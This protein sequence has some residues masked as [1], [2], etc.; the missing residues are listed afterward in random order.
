MVALT[1]LETEAPALAAP[2]PAALLGSLLAGSG[3]ELTDLEPRG[4]G[5]VA[6]VAI[7]SAVYRLA[8]DALPAGTDRRTVPR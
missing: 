7:G 5:L 2:S 1:L 8:L 4:L 6:T 3:V